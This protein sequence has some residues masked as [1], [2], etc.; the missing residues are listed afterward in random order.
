MRDGF[1]AAAFTRR[2]ALQAGTG[3]AVGTVLGLVLLAL[4]PQ[5]SEPGFFLVGIGL[6]GWHW[7]LPL[8]IPVASAGIAWA[9]TARAVRRNL[10][11]WS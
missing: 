1:V 9:A 6:A 8:A 2:F 3:A 5:A 10:R 4:L 11:K 7:I